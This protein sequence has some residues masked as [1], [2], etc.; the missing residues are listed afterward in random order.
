MKKLLL[1]LA[2]PAALH[3]APQ[4]E[5]WDDWLPHNPESHR[6]LDHSR[7]DLLLDGHLVTDDPS[8]VHLFDYDGVS[9]DD[10]QVL[11]E[12]LAYL[13]DVKVYD[14]TRD[15]QMAYWINLYNAL[16]IQVIL[17]HWP[18]ASIRDINLGGLFTR[19][20]WKAALMEVQGQQISLDDIEHRILRPIWND[21]RIHY[22]VNCASIGCPNLQPWAFTHEN[23]EELL[24]AAAV[25]F[26]HHPRAVKVSGRTLNLSSIFDWF[27]EDFGDSREGILA[28]IMG[29]AS[30]ELQ[31][32][33]APFLTGSGR[34]RYSY[35][36]SINAGDRRSSGE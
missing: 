27:S 28:H 18:V 6:T 29:Y 22:A 1:L 9:P 16:T 31:E 19:G 4:A 25:E 35:D 17:D 2:L 36:W 34:I 14:L 8:G 15:E 24:E 3:A 21:A 13:G 5:L 26:I 7:W 23:L 30:E 12:Y 33:L 11:S 32:D 10:Y 20:P